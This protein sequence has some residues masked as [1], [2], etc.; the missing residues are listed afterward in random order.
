MEYINEIKIELIKNE[1]AILN[2]V[3]SGFK[4][5]RIINGQRIELELSSQELN[6]AFNCQEHKYR[7]S[8][9]ENTLDEMVENNELKSRAAKKIRTNAVLMKKIVSDYDDNIDDHNMEWS[10]AAHDAIKKNIGNMKYT[11]ISK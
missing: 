5:M 3:S 2:D 8:D 10:D 6:N 7:I 4:I 1:M 9:I 11:N